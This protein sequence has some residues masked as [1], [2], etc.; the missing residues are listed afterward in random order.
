[1]K[2]EKVPG[3]GEMT[4]PT[5]DLR[6]AGLARKNFRE[7]RSITTCTSQRVLARAPSQAAHGIAL[8]FYFYPLFL[9]LVYFL[10]DNQKLF[11]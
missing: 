11:W 3:P 7:S 6:Q 9:G 4:A 8:E 2:M 5:T 10:G 1:M